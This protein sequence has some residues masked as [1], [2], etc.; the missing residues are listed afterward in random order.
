MAWEAWEG[1]TDHALVFSNLSG[2]P[3]NV[4]HNPF[5]P[6]P[7]TCAPCELDARVSSDG[8]LLAYRHRPDAP[9]PPERMSELSWDQWWAETQAI[10][11]EI[12]VID[13]TTGQTLFTQRVAANARLDDFDGRSWLSPTGKSSPRFGEPRNQP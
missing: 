3:V 1:G 10:P 12:T 5:P 8:Q 9:W 7:N 2:D 13:L 4:A 6:F 11:G